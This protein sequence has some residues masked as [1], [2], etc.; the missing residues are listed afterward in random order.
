[1]L[2]EHTVP[3]LEERCYQD[4]LDRYRE[5]WKT[6]EYALSALAVALYDVEHGR[7]GWRERLGDSYYPIKMSASRRARAE[8]LARTGGDCCDAMAPPEPQRDEMFI[9]AG[10]GK[11]WVFSEDVGGWVETGAPEVE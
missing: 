2:P 8:Y 4:F 3:T 5:Y 10:C 6:P 1:M 9:C 7:G 11:T